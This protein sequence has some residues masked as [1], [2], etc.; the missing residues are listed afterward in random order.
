MPNPVR[1]TKARESA[2]R[3]QGQH[4][5]S[6]AGRRP[7]LPRPPRAGRREPRGRRHARLEHADVIV[8]GTVA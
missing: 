2:H 5:G 4:R 3:P 8:R 6:W 7:L 1:T